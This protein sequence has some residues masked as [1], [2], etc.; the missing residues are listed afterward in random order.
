MLKTYTAFNLEFLCETRW[1]ERHDDIQISKQLIVPIFKGLEEIETDG[2]S[3][4]SSKARSL[5]NSILSLDYIV[6]L[7]VVDFFLGY[8]LNLSKLLQPENRDMVMRIQCVESVAKMFKEV[9]NSAEGSFHQLL[10]QATRL[11]RELEITLVM[12]RKRNLVK[13]SSDIRQ[14]IQSHESR[15]TKYKVTLK[16]LS[17]I[18]PSFVVKQNSSNLKKLIKLYASDLTSPDST[19]MTLNYGE[20]SD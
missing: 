8:T 2:D 17:G 16:G 10:I 9:Q 15:F 20:Q 14:L 13:I 3:V 4:T 6:T 1:V 11:C 12:P 7:I 19:A 18:L 5:L